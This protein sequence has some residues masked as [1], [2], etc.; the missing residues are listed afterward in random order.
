MNNNYLDGLIELQDDYDNLLKT[1]NPNQLT[2]N[3]LNMFTNEE[4]EELTNGYVTMGELPI[5]RVGDMSYFPLSAD[6]SYEST[7][8]KNNNIIGINEM[9]GTIAFL[10]AHSNGM[11]EGL[12]YTVI[13]PTNKTISYK[14]TPYSNKFLDDKGY[15]I[16]GVLGCLSEDI[17]F[18]ECHNS[19][20][21]SK[22][23]L[24]IL[25]GTLNPKY[26]ETFEIN[27]NII[28]NH[29]IIYEY[30]KYG[31]FKID[32]SIYMIKNSSDTFM[33]YE[34]Y[35]INL[36]DIDW[37]GVNTF[38]IVKGDFKSTGF[39]SKV[40]NTE[41]KFK[42]ADRYWGSSNIANQST[43]A[44]SA[45]IK[46]DEPARSTL[47]NSPVTTKYT[48]N[49]YKN[50]NK[51]RIGIYTNPYME[52][53]TVPGWSNR[54]IELFFQLELDLDKLEVK[55]DHYFSGTTIG[56][57]TVSGNAIN[58]FD[59]SG[60]N[61]FYSKKYNLIIKIFNDRFS[62]Y[63]VENVDN[64]ENA[65]DFSKVKF[66]KIFYTENLNR[67]NGSLAGTFE[68]PIRLIGKQY[69]SSHGTSKIGNN[70][71][72][73]KTFY[74]KIPTRFDYQY[75]RFDGL[76]CLGAEPKDDY[77][78]Y[79][80]INDSNKEY[81]RYRVSTVISKN[82]E[83][84]KLSK[85]QLVVSEILNYSI[86]GFFDTG[87]RDIDFNGTNFILNDKITVD[88]NRLLSSVRQLMQT[89]MGGN[90]QANLKIMMEFE[91]LSYF[92]EKD[93]YLIIMI[94]LETKTE[95]TYIMAI[96]SIFEGNVLVGVS[97]EY[98]KIS[99]S[100]RN[101]NNGNPTLFTN[102][103]KPNSHLHYLESEKVW[104]IVTTWN[105]RISVP[106]DSRYWQ[107]GIIYDTN[108]GVFNLR[109]A[110]TATP[111]TYDMHWLTF[112][113]GYGICY[114]YP[115]KIAESNSRAYFVGEVLTNPQDIV[116]LVY[117]NKIAVLMASQ[118]MPNSFILTFNEVIP[119]IFDGYY[120]EIKQ[121]TIDLAKLY[122]NNHK[123]NLFHIHVDF[124][125]NIILDVN[126][127]MSKE[128]LYLGFCQTNESQITRISLDKVTRFAGKYFSNEK[129][130]NKIA[131]SSGNILTGGNF[132]NWE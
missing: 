44:E 132:N 109:S 73:V 70:S 87:Y 72:S 114:S 117:Y 43:Y 111:N 7:N 55:I 39:D 80:S 118:V 17:M 37:D 79:G 61:Y 74:S 31:F 121:Q 22:N 119:I 83:V 41:N 91:D 40:F 10:S 127:N 131:I 57:T 112:M 35:S 50:K 68:S 52:N 9:N 12:Y 84:I 34:L 20:N 21:E 113:P 102:G 99:E 130:V 97:G 27:T 125:C 90:Y 30:R 92:S 123:N 93:L 106:G 116:S 3:D 25:N 124:D 15:K 1:P 64:W 115:G 4:F 89:V 101:Q 82:K 78:N 100:T 128:V 85:A 32:E 13:D 62:S 103:W 71:S 2:P 8:I 53:A 48:I 6:G 104:C 14:T 67:P 88:K 126:K 94:D 110:R 29:P 24:V 108:T 95:R 60:T 19:S 38:S 47:W 18:L 59:A 107:S 120:K 36:K 33:E 122:P 46:S 69:F 75:K 54:Y 129:D 16:K 66:T 105:L 45:L 23:V 81:A 49:R 77:Y 76:E 51:V 28:L 56:K 63:R 26:H 58:A 96:K 42:L 5:D 98:Q 86:E 11:S 65:L